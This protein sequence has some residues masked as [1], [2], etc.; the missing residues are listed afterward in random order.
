[1]IDSDV[2]FNWSSKKD[3]ETFYGLVNNV[4]YPSHGFK[5]LLTVNPNDASPNNSINQ[6]VQMLQ[7]KIIVKSNVIA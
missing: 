1:M 4:L 6:T 5:Q 7:V 2:R 3:G